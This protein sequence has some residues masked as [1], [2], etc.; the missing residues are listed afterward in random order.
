MTR[1][2][3]PGG[4]GQEFFSRIMVRVRRGE[5]ITDEGFVI[6]ARTEKNKT[7]TPHLTCSIPFYYD[8]HIDELNELFSAAVSL[9]II[10]RAG[11]Y[12]KFNDQQALGREGFL[13]M[14]RE[15]P[16]II[17][18]IKREVDKEL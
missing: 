15:G 18:K 9:G 4:K 8:G 10:S 11:P 16:D 2:A 6:E 13:E 3:L 7:F 1:D 14:L 12:Y 17:K 5:S